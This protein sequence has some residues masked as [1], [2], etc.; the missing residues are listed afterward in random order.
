VQAEEAGGCHSANEFDLAPVL[1]LPSRRL[2]V[3]GTCVDPQHRQG[4]AIA[5]LWPGQED[6]GKDNRIDTL[7]GCASIEMHDGGIQVQAIMNRVRK[8]A[9]ETAEQRV[10]PYRPLPRLQAGA[11]R[12]LAA[13]LPPLLKANFRLGAWA[14]REPCY[15]PAINCADIL[16]KVDVG[17]I[18]ASYTRHCLDRVMKG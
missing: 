18:D 17:E 11:E 4:A 14:C 3:G 1:S 9:M 8:H 13:P 6:Y 10:A 15:D 5:L 2:E 12:T 16:V 7:F